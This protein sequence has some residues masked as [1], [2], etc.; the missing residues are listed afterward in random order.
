MNYEKIMF[1]IGKT[2]VSIDLVEQKFSC[3]LNLC[4]G[5]CCIEGKSGAPIAKNEQLI[6][7][8]IY[9]LVREYMTFEGI[10]TVENQGWYVFDDEG[11]CVTPLVNNKQC[12]YSFFDTNGIA[13]CAFEKVFFDKITDFQKPVSCHLYPVRIT[14]YKEYDAINFESVEMCKSACEKGFNENIL[15]YVF[16]KDSLIRKYGIEWY[17]EFEFTVFEYLKK[18]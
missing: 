13:K 15:L 6:I 4:R 3:N 2:L 12:A 7:E 9:P 14:S 17:N 10:E 11:E 1:Q 8:E 5:M 16:L 18:I